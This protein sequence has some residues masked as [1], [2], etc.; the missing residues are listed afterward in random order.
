MAR[1]GLVVLFAA[2]TVA[3]P[4][5]GAPKAGSGRVSLNWRPDPSTG[6]NR[7]QVDVRGLSP[8]AL[9]RLR[10][11]TGTEAEWNKVLRV[12]V[13]P[14]AGPGNQDPP[15]MLGQHRIEGNLLVFRPRFPLQPGVPYRAE[16]RFDQLTGLH[17]AGVIQSTFRLPPL[18]LVPS[19][20]VA[21]VY[22]TAEL[23]PENLLKFYLKFSAPMS[24]GRVYE[25]LHLS[26]ETGRVVDLPFLEIDEEL[27][28]PSMTRLTLLIDPGRI[29]RG[30]TPLEEVG[31]ALQAGHSY[32]LVIDAEWRDARGAT[33]KEAFAKKF[34]VGPPD[35]RPLD[36][37]QWTV[38]APRAG[39][40]EP[41]TVEF[42]RPMDWALASRVLA[43]WRSGAGPGDSAEAGSV[44]LGPEE[45]EWRFVPDRPWSAGRWELS[46]QSTLEDLAGNNIGKSFEVDLFERVQQRV[47]NAVTQLPFRIGPANPP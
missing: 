24:G 13:E 20:V 47:T 26:D 10:N 42:H 41:L 19:T 34:R 15:P 18:A 33:L 36:P 9:T 16:A 29:K 11:V 14:G 2:T 37:D 22:P 25:H 7:W 3:A 1:L 8:E 23:L 12:V 31:P 43:V 6:T 4:G 5:D 44:I 40:R 32:T 27:W 30:V 21:A 17:L 38:L 39:S 45:R 28:D 35:R 46:I